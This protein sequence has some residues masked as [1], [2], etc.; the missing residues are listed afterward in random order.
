MSNIVKIVFCYGLGN[1][2]SNEME[3]DLSEFK[4]V[5]MDL[6]VPKTW[7]VEQLKDWLA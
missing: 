4:F 7:T 1:E 3:I 6:N 5:E 2:L